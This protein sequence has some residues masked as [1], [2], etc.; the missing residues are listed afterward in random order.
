[1]QTVQQESTKSKYEQEYKS[2]YERNKAK[3]AAKEKEKKRWISYYA[4]HREAVLAR[5]KA[6]AERLRLEKHEIVSNA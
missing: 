3:I 2:Y 4:R 1:M 6:R 5:V